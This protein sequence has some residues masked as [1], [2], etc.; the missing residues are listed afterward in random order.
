M[1][2]SATTMFVVL[3]MSIS[4]PAVVATEATEQTRSVIIE[5]LPYNPAT[6]GYASSS[7]TTELS[8][9]PIPGG[10]VLGIGAPFQICFGSTQAG[11]A[12]IWY[13]DAR[14]TVQRLYPNR[15]TGAVAR[16][17]AGREACIGGGSEGFR[18]IQ[19]GPPGVDDII[20]LWTRDASRQPGE[21]QFRSAGT[22]S[23]AALVGDY[24]T[25]ANPD[26]SRL[27]AIELFIGTMRSVLIQQSVPVNGWQT[28]RIR[29]V[30]Q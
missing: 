6:I 18:L 30:S 4:A 1:K 24:L 29:V 10:G 13:I 2:L 21:W 22:G 16:V 15:L 17:R 28:K 14:G 3:A 27:D 8:L 7:R 25:I 11:Y 20:L 23:G 5:S 12:S 9:R 19:A 26:P